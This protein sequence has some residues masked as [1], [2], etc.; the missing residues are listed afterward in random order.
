MERESLDVNLAVVARQAR[1]SHLRAQERSEPRISDAGSA[2]QMSFEAERLRQLLYATAAITAARA[3][4]SRVS[5]GRVSPL[6]HR[7]A[8][9]TPAQA[10]SL[11]PV[12][13]EQRVVARLILINVQLDKG[14]MRGVLETNRQ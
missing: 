10:V 7:T 3:S 14:Y 6:K 11:E 13:Q 1:R 2:V 5:A 12:T 4:S 9:V 8:N